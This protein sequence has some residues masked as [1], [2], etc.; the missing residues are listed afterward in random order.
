M[1]VQQQ[2]DL[3]HERKHEV[4]RK[5]EMTEEELKARQDMVRVEEALKIANRAFRE[6][7]RRLKEEKAEREAELRRALG[8]A[9]AVRVEVPME[10]ETARGGIREMYIVKQIK[11]VVKENTLGRLELFALAC[12]QAQKHPELQETYDAVFEQIQNDHHL[13]THKPSTKRRRA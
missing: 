10:E 13:A 6:E 8:D 12:S 11:R 9:K 2:H 7:E 5:D 3:A 1:R 4:V